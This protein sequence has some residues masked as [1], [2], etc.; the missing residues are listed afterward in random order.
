VNSSEHK[1][2]VINVFL[3][4]KLNCVIQKLIVELFDDDFTKLTEEEK[5]LRIETQELPF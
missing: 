4:Y 1:T 5:L 3:L 2:L